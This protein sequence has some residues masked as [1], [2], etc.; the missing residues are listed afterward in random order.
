MC[1]VSRLGSASSLLSLPSPLRVDARSVHPGP[2]LIRGTTRLRCR[3]PLSTSHGSFPSHFQVLSRA[4]LS[5]KSP[6]PSV[7]TFSPLP[8]LLPL[9]NQS[10]LE[11]AN[12]CPRGRSPIPHQVPANG[13]HINT[14]HYKIKTHCKLWYRGLCTAQNED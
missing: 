4:P 5:S 1:V 10:Q 6:S 12:H 8:H 7:F 3:S 14:K 9:P 11:W 13:T 2:S